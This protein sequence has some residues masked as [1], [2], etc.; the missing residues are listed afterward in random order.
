MKIIFV[1]GSLEP[2]KDGVGDYTFLLAK[3]FA[4]LG[5]SVIT[6]AINDP[7]IRDHSPF[8]NY[9]QDGS[10][11]IF[12]YSM[13]LSYRRRFE[14]LREIIDE[15]SVDW[16]SLQFVPFSYDRKGL[17]LKMALELTK[18]KTSA[19]WHIMF[20][21]LWVGI[22]ASFFSKY[23]WWGKFQQLILIRILNK[24]TPDVIT[25][26]CIL[27]LDLLKKIDA[28]S[29]LLPL[30]SNIPVSSL[31]SEQ[32]AAPHQLIYV[33]F[34]GIHYGA[35]VA[36]FAEETSRLVKTK[37]LQAKLILIGSSGKDSS[38][39]ISEFESRGIEVQ[40]YGIQPL[41]LVSEV[42]ASATYGIS[43]TPILLAE[44]SGSIAA[45]RAHKLPVIC[46]SREWIPKRLKVTLKA[47]DI[48][49]YNPGNLD[50]ILNANTSSETNDVYA[51]SKKL[52]GIFEVVKRD[53]KD[54]LLV[55]TQ[56]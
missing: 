14:R 23:F 33:I 35:P 54:Y 20:H 46:V 21:E 48:L 18:L 55:G 2:G 44:K 37:T 45:M 12:R 31:V 6:V 25:T 53:E 36:K 50:S 40:S 3:Q 29:Q 7:Y 10:V 24:L 27:Y 39:W 1:S 42:L 30:F 19:R 38:I 11:M 26:N 56:G 49:E 52:I 47:G 51:I 34:G 8:E 32:H 16:I 43:T 13:S 4:K 5:H 22:D 9:R 15:Y 17:P 41:E 28:K